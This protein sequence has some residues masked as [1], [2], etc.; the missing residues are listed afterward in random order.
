MHSKISAIQ[1]LQSKLVLAHWHYGKKTTEIHG[2]GWSQVKCQTRH[3]VDIKH[4]GQHTMCLMLLITCS[5]TVLLSNILWHTVKWL[6]KSFSVLLLQNDSI[7]RL[8]LIK[9]L[10]RRDNNYFMFTLIL[11]YTTPDLVEICMFLILIKYT[12]YNYNI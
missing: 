7:N 11:A 9:V 6:D 10:Q 12:Q 5:T 1:Q 2:W 3:Y 4:T 8:C